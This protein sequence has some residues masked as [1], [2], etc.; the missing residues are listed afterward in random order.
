MRDERTPRTD[1]RPRASTSRCRGSRQHDIQEAQV[2]LVDPG[3]DLESNELHAS[4]RICP[5]CGRAI[6]RKTMRAAVP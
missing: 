2:R 1:G 3:A 6:R 4:G 5:R